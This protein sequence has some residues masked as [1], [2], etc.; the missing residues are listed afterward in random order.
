LIIHSGLHPALLQ[1]AGC[2][3][4]AAA[5]ANRLYSRFGSLGDRS[6]RSSWKHPHSRRGWSRSRSGPYR[7]LYSHS[8]S[9]PSTLQFSKF[10]PPLARGEQDPY[11]CV[12][13]AP[14]WTRSGPSHSGGRRGEGD[15][16]NPIP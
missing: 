9:I 10:T 5:I 12:G 11:P 8:P 3:V 14:G 1:G 16:D 7:Q 13:S 2:W 4:R 15:R 6:C